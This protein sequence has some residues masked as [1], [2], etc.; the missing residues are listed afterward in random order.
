MNAEQVIT[1]EWE[2]LPQRSR[3]RRIVSSAPLLEDPN[4][5]KPSPNALRPSTTPAAKQ[6]GGWEYLDH[7]ADVQIHSWGANTKEAFGA[8]VVGMFG[9]MVELSEITDDLQMDI[10]VSGHNK[11]TLL[12]NFMQEC[13]YIFLTES[14]AMKE[15]VITAITEAHQHDENFDTDKFKLTATAKGGLFDATKHSQGTEIKAVTYSNLQVVEKEQ[16]RVETYVIVDI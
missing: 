6:R 12:F 7:T 3:W 1:V 16:G 11:E 14:Y 4:V 5:S 15:I 2:Q 8:A 9:Y 13:L 10:S